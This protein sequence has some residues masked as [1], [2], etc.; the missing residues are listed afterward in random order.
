MNTVG[1]IETEVP[2]Q[3]FIFVNYI[4]TSMKEMG[5]RMYRGELLSGSKS[6]KKK[7]RLAV[8]D[9]CTLIKNTDSLQNCKLYP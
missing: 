6:L 9:N 3:T 2:M 4:R 1:E 5:F 8:T 7:N